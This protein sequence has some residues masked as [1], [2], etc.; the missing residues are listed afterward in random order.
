MLPL[1]DVSALIVVSFSTFSFSEIN[2][3]PPNILIGPPSVDCIHTSPSPLTFTP[4]S[5][6]SNSKNSSSSNIRCG[7]AVPLSISIEPVMPIFPFTSMLLLNDTSLWIS[8]FEPL[9]VIVVTAIPSSNVCCPTNVLE[10][11][12]VALVFISACST[13]EL[14]FNCASVANVASNDELKFNNCATLPE[15]DALSVL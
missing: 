6:P 5:L 2:T 7:V 8:I 10:P 1:I 3:S 14:K 11:V 12:T 13:D 4:P 15:R 9:S